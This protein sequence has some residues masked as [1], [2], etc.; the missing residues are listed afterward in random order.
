MA[1]ADTR[2][3]LPTESCE[4]PE[5]IPRHIGIRARRTEP[6]P[7]GGPDSGA[8]AAARVALFV[9]RVEDDPRA[10]LGMEEC[11]LLRHPLALVRERH[12]R[13]DPHVA[14]QEDRGIALGPLHRPALLAGMD[15]TFTA[16]LHLAPTHNE[17]LLCDLD[18]MSSTGTL[19][20]GSM[21]LAHWLD[22]AVF[23][24]GPR[25][26]GQVFAEARAQLKAR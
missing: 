12:H 15:P 3:L 16:S 21:P 19:A 5:K 17:Q 20:D 10:E 26:E 9:E 14:D 24:A 7:A 23:L 13:L 22:N 4:M 8:A 6:P 25:R 1:R 11:G 18:E 2:L